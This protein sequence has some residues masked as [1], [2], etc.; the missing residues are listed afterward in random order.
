MHL[1]PGT[2]TDLLLSLVLLALLAAAFWT[3]A[4]AP[5]AAFR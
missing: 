5:S 2:K 4:T 1:R 3:V